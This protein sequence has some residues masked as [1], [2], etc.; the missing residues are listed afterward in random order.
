MIPVVFFNVVDLESK[1]HDMRCEEGNVLIPSNEHVG[2][3]S[4]C[5]SVTVAALF[6]GFGHGENEA[7]EGTCLAGF[8]TGFRIVVEV[9][10]FREVSRQG[11][12]ID[13]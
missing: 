3:S 7:V 6:R 11:D 2:E 12:A 1:S 10:T 13:I 8:R 4:V 5:E 9:E